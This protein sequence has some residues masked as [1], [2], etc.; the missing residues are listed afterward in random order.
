MLSRNIGP[1]EARAMASTTPSTIQDSTQLR[2]NRALT[3]IGANML[4]D[5]GA[6]LVFIGMSTP[7]QDIW[8]A[9]HAARLP[10]VVL[11]GVGAA[12]DFHGEDV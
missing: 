8:M 7:K 3:C 9:E 5:S 4:L 10:G 2:K 11:F 12:F 6:D 1:A